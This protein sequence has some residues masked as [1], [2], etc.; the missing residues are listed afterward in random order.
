MDSRS[1][2]HRFVVGLWFGLHVVWPILSGLLMLIVALGLLVGRCEGWRISE[3][4]YFSFVTAL[5]IGYGD[6]APKMLITRSLAI[7]IGLCG[8]LLTAI[9]AAVAVKALSALRQDDE[10]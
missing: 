4:L 1:L 7:L 3:S 8:V 9:V 2:R 6:L 10:L 5:T